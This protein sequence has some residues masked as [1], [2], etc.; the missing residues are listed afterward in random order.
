[1]IRHGGSDQSRALAEDGRAW[2][3]A[4][5][6][7]RCRLALPARRRGVVPA[8]LRAHW[9]PAQIAGGLVRESPEAPEMRVCHETS[10]R[11][12]C[13]QTRGA[14]KRERTAPLRPRR[15]RRRSK[16]ATKA[17]QT[18]SAAGDYQVL[19]AAHDMEC[20][21]SGVGRAARPK[22]RNC[23]R[24]RT[25]EILM[26]ELAEVH[27]VIPTCVTLDEAYNRW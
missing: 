16:R 25:D 1:M 22:A 20:S 13:V 19:L 2:H 8:T 9:S 10:D 4:K 26:P 3:H 5:R 18:R 7:T 24:E 11:S 23:A 17:G 6:P 27:V 14:L 12:L 21:M 15:P